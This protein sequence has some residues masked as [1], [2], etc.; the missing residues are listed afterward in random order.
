VAALLALLSS[1]TWGTSDFLGGLTSRR[2]PVAAVYGLSQAAGLVALAIAV[3]VTG[4]WAWDG[5]AWGWSVVS[6]LLGLVAMLAFYSA[7]SAGPMG[8]VAPLVALSTAVPVVVGIVRGDSPAI[9]QVF[10][11]VVA[12]AGIVL[13]SGPEV[14][15]ARSSRPLMLAGV[16]ALGFGA[17]YVTMAEGSAHDP[18]L[19]MTGMRLT[20]VVVLGAV[21]VGRRSIGGAVR[22]DALPLVTI[23]VLDAGANLSYGV[24]TTLGLLSTTAVLASLYPVVTAVLAAVFLHERLRRVQY[25]GVAAVV[26]GVVLISIG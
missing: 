13:A 9:W 2:L 26:A 16:A 6:G 3:T 14:T 1:V 25:A 7:L 8:I 18:L 10:G 12:V 11:I 4:G 17:M 19:T 5:G 20:V 24:A 15:S 23:G 22:R 21:A